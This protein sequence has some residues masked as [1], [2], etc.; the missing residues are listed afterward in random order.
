MRIWLSQL[1]KPIYD[2]LLLIL[3]ITHLEID[4]SIM[5][6]TT[7]TVDFSCLKIHLFLSHHKAQTTKDGEHFQ[8]GAKRDFSCN[9]SQASNKSHKEF[10]NSIEKISLPRRKNQQSWAKTHWRKTWS[11]F[12]KN[13]PHRRHLNHWAILNLS[14]L[15]LVNG[16]F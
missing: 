1:E 2:D 13:C 11:T 15:S 12:S 5:P 4:F 16:L 3:D 6:V 8:M 14:N 7:L 10:G 9:T